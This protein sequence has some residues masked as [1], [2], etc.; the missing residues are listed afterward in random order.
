MGKAVKHEHKC[1]TRKYILSSVAMTWHVIL[2]V[3]HYNV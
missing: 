3:W 2:G 1:F